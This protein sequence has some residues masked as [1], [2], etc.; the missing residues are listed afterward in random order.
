[1][2]RVLVVED[3]PAIRELVGAYVKGAGHSVAM[4]SNGDEALETVAER[5]APDIAVLDVAM[6]GMS[7]LDLLVRLRELPGQDELPAIFLS[8]RVK[9]EDIAK[10]TALNAAYLTKPFVGSALVNLI[11]KVM[12][13]AGD[14]W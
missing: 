14:D 4:A 3:N 2:T 5:G 10:G 6:P 7:G 11:D 13:P 9:P 1:M 12:R 8:A